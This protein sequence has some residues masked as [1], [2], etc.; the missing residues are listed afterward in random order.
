MA[1]ESA[2]GNLRHRGHPGRPMTHEAAARQYQT[3]DLDLG[4]VLPREECAGQSP[5]LHAQLL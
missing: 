2:C 1:M 5:G 4:P 3:R